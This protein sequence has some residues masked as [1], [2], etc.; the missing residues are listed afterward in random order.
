MQ[1]R[2]SEGYS[3]VN[4]PKQPVAIEPATLRDRLS[5]W[6]ELLDRC[7]RK[8]TRK[9]V[10]AL[11]VVTLRLQAE[12]ERTVSDLPSASH[13]AQAI[14]NFDKQAEKLR[15]ALGRVRE[16]DVWIGKLRGLRASLTQTAGYVP[17]STRDCVRQ[18]EQ[19]EEHL[20]ENRQA[21]EKKLLA[22]IARRNNQLAKVGKEAAAAVED[23]HGVPDPRAFEMILAQ[24]ARV[25]AEFPALDAENLHEFRKRIKT[26]RYLAEISAADPACS[27]LAGQM[28]KLQSAIG[29]WHDWDALVREIPQGRRVRNSHLSELLRAIAAETFIEATSTCHSITAR[30]LAG[31]PERVEPSSVPVRKSPAQSDGVVA[32]ADLKKRA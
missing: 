23:R 15:Q 25:A 26:V 14:L 13:Q 8:P 7:R 11:R 32:A 19:L 17:R 31:A 28:K 1:N 27:R 16:L 10:H 12:L 5:N 18:I 21:A 20:K 24:F 3:L 9:R 22:E 4:S 2:G 30:L 6:Q 29:E